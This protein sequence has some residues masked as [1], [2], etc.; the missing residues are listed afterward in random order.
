MDA[1]LLPFSEETNTQSQS[2]NFIRNL[3]NFLIFIVVAGLHYLATL[4]P[5]LIWGLLPVQFFVIYLLIKKYRNI[6]WSD[7]NMASF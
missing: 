2:G 5:Y 3:L 4:I 7:V 1:P 6:P